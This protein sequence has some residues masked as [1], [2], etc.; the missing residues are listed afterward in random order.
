MANNH[1]SGVDAMKN[2]LL[3]AAGEYRRRVER[4][5][6]EEG[7][8]VMADSQENYVPVDLGTL[9]TSGRT[10]LPVWEG[11][12]CVVTLSYGGAAE[13]YA[14]AVHEHL[15]KH[16]PYSWRVAKNVTFHPAGR[17]PKY[18]EKP[19][20]KHSRGMLKRLQARIF[21]TGAVR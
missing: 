10:H 8:F 13:E 4:A 19:I 15:S 11:D 2:A 7:S 6:F 9:K 20:N 12:T 18:L 16:S 3:S 21:S 17:G 5:L 1:L 14:L